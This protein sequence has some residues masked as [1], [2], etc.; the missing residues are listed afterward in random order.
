MWD[1]YLRLST[2]LSLPNVSHTHI[3]PDILFPFNV[4]L[5]SHTWYTTISL[6]SESSIHSFGHML[7][8]K[9]EFFH[10]HILASSLTPTTSMG[11]DTWPPLSWKLLTQGTD[12]ILRQTI[13][14][15]TILGFY[16]RS[17]SSLENRLVM[18]ELLVLYKHYTGHIYKQCRK[19]IPSY[20]TQWRCLRLQI[21][22]PQM[23][24]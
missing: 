23:P 11:H 21:K 18:W 9:Q 20:P 14:S 4:R 3:F 1:F 12:W 19:S 17:N 22:A 5:I 16:I 13:D 7:P 8:F 2:P 10:P 24:Q 15:D 6:S